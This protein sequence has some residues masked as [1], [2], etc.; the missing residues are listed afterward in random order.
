M[1]G[2]HWLDKIIRAEHET[3]AQMEIRMPSFRSIYQ[4]SM[5]FNEKL[6]SNAAYTVES[7]VPHCT[8]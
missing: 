3:N 6:V 8:W 4:F 7:N 5:L 2:L 1:N